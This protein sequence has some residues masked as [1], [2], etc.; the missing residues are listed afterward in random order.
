MAASGHKN[1]SRVDHEKKN[2][3]GWLVRIVFQGRRHQKFFSDLAHHG[4]RAA[5]KAA[6]EWRNLVEKK[7]GKPRTERLVA[8]P[9]NRN[10]SGV[11]GV[12][13]TTKAMTRDGKKKGPV[14]E[15]W[16][17]PEPGQI[18][19]TS[20]SI[21]KYGELEAFRRALAIRKAGEREMYGVELSPIKKSRKKPSKRR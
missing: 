17:F 2:A 18:R 20:V 7:I 14:Y 5:L 3:F 8:M 21:L 12:R 6:V 10:R 16:W 15:V 1:I 19:K 9:T 13:R 4:K 11:V